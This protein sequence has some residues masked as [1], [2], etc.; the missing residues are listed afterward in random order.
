[1]AS[2][3]TFVFGS[4][5]PFTPAPGGINLPMVVMKQPAT[6]Q[7]MAPGNPAARDTDVLDKW[8]CLYTQKRFNRASVA[9]VP[10]TRFNRVVQ[11]A[12]RRALVRERALR[13]QR[14]FEAQPTKVIYHLDVPTAVETVSEPIVQQPQQRKPIKRAPI[15]KEAPITTNY[16]R[17]VAGLK[18]VIKHASLIVEVRGKGRKP[19]VCVKRKMGQFAAL[20]AQTHHELGRLR[21]VDVSTDEWTM[22]VLAELAGAGPLSKKRKWSQPLKPGDSGMI[23][24]MG[25]FEFGGNTIA[26]PAIIRGELDG[27]LISASKKLSWA[28]VARVRHFSNPALPFWEG[29]DTTFRGVRRVPTTHQSCERDI[30]LRD[31]GCEEALLRQAIAPCFKVTCGVCK[32]DLANTSTQVYRKEA[33]SRIDSILVRFSDIPSGSEHIQTAL[34]HVRVALASHIDDPAELLQARAIV[35]SKTEGPF[36]LLAQL[37]D[38]A[39]KIGELNANDCKD[40]SHTILELTRW[41]ANRTDS[42]KRGDL[43][44]FRN[45]ASGKAH[46][47]LA[48]MCDNQ[49]DSNGN[50]LWGERSYHARRF[51]S[52]FFE[53]IEPGTGYAKHMIRRNPFGERRLA[54]GNLVVSLDLNQL[55]S[56]LTGERI[57]AQPITEQCVAKRD[58]QFVYQCSCVT[59]EDGNPQFSGVIT[60]AKNHLVIGSTGD[61][62]Y[63]DLPPNPSRRLYIAKEGYCYMNIFLAMLV[64]VPEGEAKDFTKRVRDTL[65]PQLGEWPT[66]QQVATACYFL[67]I[68]HPDTR[69]A[70]LPRILV[71]HTAKVLHVVDSYGTLTTGYHILKANSVNQLIDF[72]HNDLESAMKEYKV[73]GLVRGSNKAVL[74]TLVRAVYRP[75]E[76]KQLL[77]DEPYIL[78]LALLSPRI[79]RA[80]TDGGAFEYAIDHWI[81]HNQTVAGILS[82]M[83]ILAQRCSVARTLYQQQLC[84]E[85]EAHK[86]FQLVQGCS[87]FSESKLLVLAQLDLISRRYL[88]DL[89]LAAGGFLTDDDYLLASVEKNYDAM[90]TDSW[91]GL[92]FSERLHYVLH[93]RKYSRPYVDSS[94]REEHESTRDKL[95]KFVDCSTSFAADKT[96]QTMG[97][98]RGRVS[99]VK[100]GFTKFCA[101]RVMGLI[102]RSLPHHLRIIDTL[103][104]LALILTISHRLR[105]IVAAHRHARWL[106]QQKSAQETWRELESVIDKFEEHL[107]R[108]ASD[109]EIASHLEKHFPH[110]EASFRKQTERVELQAKR[111]ASEAYL[112]KIV[113]MVALCTMIFGS[114][115]SDGVFKILS[116]LKT[117]FTT[118]HET[119][120]F[121]STSVEGGDTR[122]E[123]KLLTIDFE[124]SQEVRPPIAQMDATFSAWWD[125]QIANGNTCPHYQNSGTFIEFTRETAETVAAKIAHTDGTQEFLIR[126]AVGSGKSTGLPTYLSKRGRVLML[127]P[128]RPLAEN[129]HTQLSREP[130]FMSATLRMRNHS[131]FGSSPITVMTSGYALHLFANNPTQLSEY[132][133]VIF[134][135]CHVMDASAMAFYCALKEYSYS[136]KILKVSATP[137][138]RECEFSTQKPV[139]L[140]CEESL[141]FD[142]FVRSQRTGSNC[143]VVKDGNNILVYVASY[144]DVDKLAKLLSE[145]GFSVMKVDGRTMKKGG[146]NIECDGTVEKPLFVVATN[147][148]EN[149]VTINVDVVVDF[150]EKVTAELDIDNRAMVYRKTPVSYGE[151]QQRLGRV[152]RFK[153]GA[154][155]RIGHTER[156]AQPVTQAIATE[157]AFY[158]F[159]YGLPVITHN[160]ATSMLNKVTTKQA[161]TMMQFEL[162]MYF[163][164]D[165]VRYDGMMHPAVYAVL[166]PFKLR[167]S[168]TVLHVGASPRIA[169]KSWLTGEQYSRRGF[170]NHM[171]AHVKTPFFSNCIPDTLYTKL[172]QAVETCKDVTHF[173]SLSSASACKIAYTLQTDVFAIPRTLGM[174]EHLI[175]E[176]QTKHAC[177]ESARAQPIDAQGG[178]ITAIINLI[179][180]KLSVDHSMDNIR[181]LE[182][183]RGQL[184]E[185]ASLDYDLSKPALLRQFGALTTVMFQSANEVAAAVGLKGRWLGSLNTTNLV[186]V[187]ALAVGGAVMA[188][189]YFTRSSEEIVEFQGFA[190]RQ[191]QK[192]KFRNARDARLGREVFG[193]EAVE[194]HFGDAYSKKEKKKGK[195]VGM[196]IKNRRFINF[197]G[198]DPTD[199]SIVRFVDPLTG[200]M[201]EESTTCDI[202]LVQDELNTKRLDMLDEDLISREAMRYHSGVQ[203]YF[204]KHG[205]DTALKVD[206]TPHLPLKVCEGANTIAGFPERSGELRQTGRATQVNVKDIPAPGKNV[207]LEGAS[208]YGGPRDYNPIANSICQ[209]VNKSEG[210]GYQMFGIGFGPLII[211]S[212]HFFMHGNSGEMQVRSKH[213]LF[214]VPCI[215]S[216]RVQQVEGRDL[217]IIWMPKDFPPFPS[218]IKFASPTKGSSVCMVNTIFNTGTSTSEVSE[219]CMTFPKENTGFWMHWIST[220][221]GHCGLPFVNTS[222]GAIVGLHSLSSKSTV[223]N[224]YTGIPDRFGERFLQQPAV[225]EWVRDWQFNLDLINW[226]GMNV[227]NATPTGAFRPTKSVTLLPE[228]V[229]V[230]GREDQAS[231]LAPH[232][233]DNLQIVA[234]CPNQLVTKHIVKG[235]CPHFQLYLS[236]HPKAE[237]YFKPLMGAYGKSA[238]NKAAFIKDFTKYSGPIEVGMVDLEAFERAVANVITILKRLDIQE[239]EYVND[240]DAIFDSLN[241]NAAV[242]ALY[243]GK[244]KDY[245]EGYTP[246]QYEDTLRESCERVFHG[247][248]GVWN[249]SLKAELRPMEKVLANKTRVFTAAPL[250]SLLAN[251]LCVDDFNNRFY[252]AH[253]KGPWT[254]GISKFYRGWD[255]LMR[256][257]PEGWVYC[258]ADG[259]RFDSSLT[260][261]LLNAVL[262]VRLALMEEW[263]LGAQLMKNL[264]AEIVYT[265][266]ATPDGSVVK[267]FKGNNSGQASTVVD[268]SLMVIITMQYA[269][270]RQG[271]HLDEQN[272]IIRYFVNGDDLII[273]VE[274]THTDILARLQTTFAEL[275]LDFDFSH[276]TENRT[277][278]SYMSHQGLL[279][280]GVYIPKICRERIVSILEWDRSDSPQQRLDAICA[281]QIEAWGYDDLLQEIRE[282]YAWLI[283]M[284][285]FRQVAAEG[286]APY[287]AETALRYLYL[288]L[289]A[290]AGELERYIQSYEQKLSDSVVEDEVLFQSGT[291]DAGSEDEKRKRAEEKAKREA[292]QAQGSRR[293]EDVNASTKG[294]YI[295]PR[296]RRMTKMRTPKFGGKEL[297]NLD[298][299]L[300]YKPDELELSNTRATQ[301]Q[302]NRWCAKVM[303][304]YQVK[305]DEFRII[306]NGLMVWCI[307]NGTSPNLNGNWTMMDRDEQV[308]YPLKPV[309]ENAQPTFRQIMAHFSNA[310]EA[311]IEMRNAEEPYMPRYGLIRNLTDMSL[312]RYAF[313]FYEVHARTPVRARE[314]HMQM[315]AAALRGSTSRL[316]GLDGNVG[317]ATEDTER[318]TADDVNRNMHSLMGL[319]L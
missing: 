247:K 217:V 158:C 297:L 308:E 162:P 132:Q 248:F 216:L 91:T 309:L 76:L 243:T 306:A 117:V 70:E 113:A 43:S 262:R 133:F 69:S 19:A 304:A 77:V 258:D 97:W 302:F 20:H 179:R 265:P 13:Q 139:D 36:K 141:S 112:E 182:A 289:D 9:I 122:E 61:A 240:P 87:H 253:L 227:V 152:G 72:A 255:H 269:L 204:I 241:K 307:E 285:P 49:L 315:K 299:L 31:A 281:A 233:K 196:G 45:K 131:C 107:G 1:M 38:G 170:R 226:G 159:A 142:T 230:Q 177:F 165:L 128:T 102:W 261:L 145:A 116:K 17:V 316:F 286:G 74:E 125:H 245:F 96:K 99:R 106:N 65:V 154:A 50:F 203:A 110:L 115:C 280:D 57:E 92:T 94:H 156:G 205:S 173:Q 62:K 298:H 277:E 124:T 292:E 188:Y 8:A 190:K 187:G 140:R 54:I 259:S 239:C 250:D 28:Q 167:E 202:Q 267:K 134:D 175:Q 311:Y 246:Q 168:E 317:D 160:V 153:A 136:G 211:T 176:E 251:K 95:G 181:R 294:T 198:F 234:R 276:Q 10:A 191:R 183:A 63:V 180:S 83:R 224:Y 105:K 89:Q 120:A 313:D 80:M 6:T 236:T 174:I 119:V 237:A 73:G 39:L 244:K 14:E 90:L 127:E 186:L 52:N 109:A 319:K 114:E 305:E 123:D 199:Y 163:M 263:Q 33:L 178:T 103:T 268:N 201:L 22:R 86:L 222:T 208:V 223:V 229:V 275:G 135:E 242:G 274:P 11:D 42:I 129:V 314:A 151:R 301:A 291:E 64:N 278:L 231:W 256:L 82:Q 24:P 130:F 215:K 60:P 295:I 189:Q 213:G 252:A 108:E 161:R 85:K 288:E 58:G 47:N 287:V 210:A 194:Y 200:H 126:G 271:I 300:S 18:A 84:I 212:A 48:L 26:G 146:S 207:E 55:R 310:A 71:D 40:L 100:R 15:V 148:I 238:L 195:K 209:L 264:Y 51:F 225:Q 41:C 67:T 279:R 270:E 282:F 164:A 46:I 318:H 21:R 98:A 197:Y 27:T 101:R 5:A 32:Q 193:E 303:D 66:L 104:V 111:T 266:I 169:A 232:I 284:E 68:F 143:D 293:G 75:N 30:T 7:G 121:E 44:T 56:Q 155:L 88:T 221:G 16:Q 147:I 59:R 35:G 2:F 220:N 29:F 79:L 93:A 150:G 312:A 12:R 290:D 3:T 272:G 214:K 144:N 78:I 206:L 53:E 257:L 138:G 260:P 118:M 172:W 185:F 192:L 235:I 296:L 273:A 34:M 171:E 219:S 137:P 149:G 81:D 166:K 157:A 218:K 228:E 184:L 249:G 37:C 254:V 4:N 283:G 25:T 23:L